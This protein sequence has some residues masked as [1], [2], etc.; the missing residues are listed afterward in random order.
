M[1]SA[2]RAGHWLIADAQHLRSGADGSYVLKAPADFVIEAQAGNSCAIGVELHPFS[3][4]QVVAQVL[5]KRHFYS[6]NQ[7]D[8]HSHLLSL[9]SECRIDHHAESK[10]ASAIVLIVWGMSN[11]F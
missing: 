7:V 6:G 5:R 9:G 2:G 11:L 10:L 8:D 4:R 3:A 1:G